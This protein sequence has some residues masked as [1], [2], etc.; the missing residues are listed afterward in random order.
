MDP[1]EN[2]WLE[3]SLPAVQTT[4]GISAKNKWSNGIDSNWQLKPMWKTQIDHSHSHFFV[5]FACHTIITLHIIHSPSISYVLFINLKNIQIFLWIFLLQFDMLICSSSSS[6]FISGSTS[7]S[8]NRSN[9]M[10]ISSSRDCNAKTWDMP[11]C[12][13]GRRKYGIYASSLS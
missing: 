3:K 1:Y 8:H 2:R 5:H 6:L 13:P 9:A 4:F 10:L 12:Q 11:L 7:N